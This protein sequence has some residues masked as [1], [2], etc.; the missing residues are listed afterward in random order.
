MS[1]CRLSSTQPRAPICSGPQQSKYATLLLWGLRGQ[2][3]KAPLPFFLQ[4]FCQPQ[5]SSSPLCL[6]SLSVSLRGGVEEGQGLPCC[7]LLTVFRSLYSHPKGPACLS[8]QS[9]LWR[10]GRWPEQPWKS[11]TKLCSSGLRTLWLGYPSGVFPIQG[12]PLFLPA[13]TLD[14]SLESSGHGRRSCLNKQLWSWNHLGSRAPRGREVGAAVE[15]QVPGDQC[16]GVTPSLPM[17]GAL[18]LHAAQGLVHFLW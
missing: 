18:G 13:P 16:R 5:R 14:F 11:V 4:G 7:R 15:A 3:K 1:P 10:G 8:G 17:L 12:Q 2:F 6:R 9:A